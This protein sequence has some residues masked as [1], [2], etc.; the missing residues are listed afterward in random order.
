[1]EIAASF[2]QNAIVFI[3]FLALMVGGVIC[4]KK[5]RDKKD[6]GKSN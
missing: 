4:G 2:I 1:M 3:C 5:F 6:S